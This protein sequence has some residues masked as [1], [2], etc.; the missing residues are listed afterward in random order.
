VELGI[1]EFN[2]TAGLEYPDG[3]TV[4]EDEKRCAVCGGC[5]TDSD[6]NPYPEG[7]RVAKYGSTGDEAQFICEVVGQC[8]MVKI[9]PNCE[10]AQVLQAIGAPEECIV[11][12]PTGTVCG[13]GKCVNGNCLELKRGEVGKRTCPEGYS[14]IEAEQNADADIKT[15]KDTCREAAAAMGE[16]F[17]EE[18]N[19]VPLDDDTWACTYC[20]GCQQDQLPVKFGRNGI[21]AEYICKKEVADGRRQL[22]N[23]L[24]KQLEN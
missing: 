10:E 8:A 3:T 15:S 24:V 12:K 7:V 4:P 9:G 14:P 11:K 13:T 16:P 5:T 22:T 23:R 17:W 21:Q 6:G 2:P 18:F 19:K 20:G 1:E